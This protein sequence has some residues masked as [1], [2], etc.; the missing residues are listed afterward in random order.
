[1]RGR[2]GLV[3]KVGCGVHGSTATTSRRSRTVVDFGCLTLGAP[4]CD[5]MAAL[6]FP[7]ESPREVCRAALD[8][9]GSSA[10]DLH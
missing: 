6:M 1:M 7:D 8:P 9:D 3:F 2:V 10:T 4:A 5:L